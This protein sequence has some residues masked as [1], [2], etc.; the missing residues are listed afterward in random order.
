MHTI[1][2]INKLRVL[3][4]IGVTRDERSNPQEIFIKVKIKRSNKPKA[5]ETDN[6]NDAVCY[7][8]LSKKVSEYCADNEFNLVECLAN[9]LFELISDIFF[10]NAI[11]GKNNGITITITVYK[12][13]QIPN[14][15]GYVSFAFNGSL[16]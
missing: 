11:N 9:G 6:I 3:V 12:K 8:S 7:D 13:P 1:L 2:L 15:D 14:L 4:K 5:C 16:L 10:Y